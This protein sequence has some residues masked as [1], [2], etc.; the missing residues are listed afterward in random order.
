MMCLDNTSSSS[1]KIEKIAAVSDS[2]FLTIAPKIASHFVQAEVR[3]FPQAER[4]EA[5]AWFA[6]SCIKRS[7]TNPSRLPNVREPKSSP[8]T[9][10]ASRIVQVAEPTG[11]FIKLWP[12]LR[13]SD[14][15]GSLNNL[16][17]G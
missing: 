1:Q 9:V 16:E 4:S 11:D 10:N 13:T 2:G 14:A 7:Q 5:L 15:C 3:H 12:P 6:P 8:I 17:G